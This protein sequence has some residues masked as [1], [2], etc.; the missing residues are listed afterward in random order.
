MP[1]RTYDNLLL[2]KDAGAVTVDAAAQVGGS[3]RVI[4]VGDAHMD[5]IAVIDTSAV[6][7]SGG[8]TYTVRIQG[9]TT[10][11]FGTPVE[12]AARA[13][14]STGRTEIPFNN[15]IGGLYYRYLRAFND[16]SGATPSIN[17]TIF[18]GKQ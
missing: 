16:T 7:T 1:S 15:E 10:L 13:I 14:T 8:N 12:L 9:S 11:A 3:A 2:L 4:D 17:S 6:D 5:G 18:I